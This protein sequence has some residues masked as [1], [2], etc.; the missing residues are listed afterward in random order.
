MDLTPVPKR[1]HPS[2]T[3]QG[4]M[5]GLFRHMSGPIVNVVFNTHSNNESSV[6]WGNHLIL[7]SN[8]ALI[9]KLNGPRNAIFKIENLEN[10]FKA[11]AATDSG[12][13]LEA[14]IVEEVESAPVTV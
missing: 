14:E 5:H 6:R 13:R 7:A 8:P 1:A 4:E 3:W 10:Y 12:V 11:R 2:Q 9:K